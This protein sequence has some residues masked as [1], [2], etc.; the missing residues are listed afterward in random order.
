MSRVADAVL[1]S[2][3]D[4]SYASRLMR[5]WYLKRFAKPVSEIQL[6]MFADVAKERQEIARKSLP[7]VKRLALAKNRVEVYSRRMAGVLE[8]HGIRNWRFRC[9]PD[10]DGLTLS[11][12]A[13]L[14]E[15][16]GVPNELSITETC[17]VLLSA[18]ITPSPNLLV[19]VQNDF[20][21]SLRLSGLRNVR[22]QRIVASD[23]SG[24]SVFVNDTAPTTQ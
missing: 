18:D 6:S 14:C 13:G 12:G 4:S 7:R 9:R 15:L 2:Q 10:G 22:L 20:T 17:D 19:T 11:F 23:D 16:T 21:Y 24:T 1:Y 3:G 5:D 8:E